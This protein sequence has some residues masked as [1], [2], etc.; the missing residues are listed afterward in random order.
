MSSVE[1]TIETT[2]R[3]VYTTPNPTDWREVQSALHQI[4]E[5]LITRGVD[6]NWDDLVTVEACDDE[7][8]F[9]TEIKEVGA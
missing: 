7:I 8:R 3:L 2:H 4:R 1:H 5:D 6:T 9:S